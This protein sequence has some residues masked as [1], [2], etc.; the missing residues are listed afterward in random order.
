MTASTLREK[1]AAVYWDTDADPDQ[2]CRLL[3]GDIESIGHIDRANLYG[4]LLM[5]YDWYTL[6]AMIPR[7]RLAEMLSPSVLDRLY[8]PSLRDRYLYARRILLG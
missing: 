8:P 3:Y 4:R 5:T 1:L 7:D 2:L 6:L